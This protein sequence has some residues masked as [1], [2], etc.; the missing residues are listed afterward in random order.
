[1]PTG[2][3]RSFTER[4]LFQY[5]TYDANHSFLFK[6]SI[7][8]GLIYTMNVEQSLVEAMGYDRILLGIEMT[9][10]RCFGASETLMVTDTYQFDDYL[11]RQKRHRGSWR[12]SRKIAGR[13]LKWV[14]DLQ[15]KRL[16]LQRSETSLCE[17]RKNDNVV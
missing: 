10:K 1:M 12:F 9:F 17:E 6:R 7:S 14:P 5:L 13:L 3:I 4:L 2:V 8:T 16:I 11:M 15:V